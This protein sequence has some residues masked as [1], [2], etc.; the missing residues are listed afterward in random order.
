VL[1]MPSCAPLAW[2]CRVELGAEPCGCRACPALKATRQQVAAWVDAAAAQLLAGAPVAALPSELHEGLEAARRRVAAEGRALALGAGPGPA[3]AAANSPGGGAGGSAAAWMRAVGA[4]LAQGILSG[5]CGCE[6]HVQAACALQIRPRMTRRTL[7]TRAPVATLGPLLPLTRPLCNPAGTPAWVGCGAWRPSCVRRCCWPSWTAADWHRAPPRSQ[8]GCTPMRTRAGGRR[9]RSAGGTGAVA[10]R[11]RLLRCWQR[12]LRP[13]RRACCTAGALSWG[14]QYT[15]RRP[16]VV[17]GATGAS[18]GARSSIRTVPCRPAPHLPAQPP[19]PPPALPSTADLAAAVAALPPTAQWLY[20]AHYGL[21]PAGLD[22]GSTGGEAAAGSVARQRAV[23]AA[24]LVAGERDGLKAAGEAP[25]L[26]ASR[27]ARR[28]GPEPC[29]SRPRVPGLTLRCSFCRAGLAGSRSQQLA[30]PAASPAGPAAALPA[31]QGGAHWAA[32]CA[33]AVPSQGGGCRAH[34]ASQPRLPHPPRPARPCRWRPHPKRR[35]PSAP[36][37]WQWPS[38]PPRRTPRRCWPRAWAPRGR[39]A[40]LQARPRQPLG[41][42]A[43]GLSRRQARVREGTA[44][45]ARCWGEWSAASSPRGSRCAQ[46]RAAR[47]VTQPAWSRQRLPYDTH[48][49]L[50]VP[51]PSAAPVLRT[52]GAVA[53]RRGRGAAR[54]G[55]ARRGAASQPRAGLAAAGAGRRRGA[56]PAGARPPRHVSQDWVRGHLEQR[57]SPAAARR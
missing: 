43:A 51:S 50:H 34:S 56:L 12:R 2:L 11:Q 39:P 49:G 16:C 47:R 28:G 54:R 35:P 46:P 6:A 53:R 57:A 4:P 9:R 1:R 27:A 14:L 13:R 19:P 48:G 7:A 29:T 8:Q 18:V 15:H 10:A 40:P 25:D 52:A 31:R 21:W 3:P 24:A 17:L 22:D 44:L 55:E 45:W 30:G 33:G 23:V 41:W 36:A 38:Q 37:C 32:R 20:D 42:R 26:Q 5:G